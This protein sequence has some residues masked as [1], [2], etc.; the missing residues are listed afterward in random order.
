MRF[1]TSRALAGLLM[2]AGLCAAQSAEP[3]KEPAKFYK[4]DFVV[5]EMDGA[6]VL[7]ARNYFMIVSTA[8]GNNSAIRT[9]SK[10]PVANNADGTN[11]SMIDIGTNVDC[12]EVTDLGN[13]ISLQLTAEV[14]SMLETESVP[15]HPIIRQNR[16]NSNVVIPLKKPTIVFSSDDSTSKHVLQ[17]EVTATPR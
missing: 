17:L 16:W 14:S 15:R 13:D 1:T 12:R 2:M 8:K 4:L 5:K 9:G 3:V 10:V 7:T 11:F 6:K